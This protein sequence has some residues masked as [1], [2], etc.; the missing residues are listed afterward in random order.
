MKVQSDKYLYLPEE[1][2]KMHDTCML[3]IKQMEDFITDNTY[4]DLKAF[5][6]PINESEQTLLNLYNGDI[7][8]FLLEINR[9]DEFERLVVYNLIYG[10][11]IDNCYFL[12]EAFNC[13]SKKRLV[14]SFSLLRRPLVFNMV[15][16]LRLLFEDDFLNKFIR[17]KELYQNKEIDF[18]A[19][20]FPHNLKDLLI[21]SKGNLIM[22]NIPGDV[23]Y[24][25]V[26]NKNISDS[27]I[28]MSDKAL[29]PV[30]TRI[31]NNKT[32]PMNLNFV[33][34]TPEAIH[35]QWSYIYHKMPTILLYYI[36]L[37]DTLVFS[38]L[39]LS[40]LD[41]VLSE[42]HRQRLLFTKDCFKST[43]S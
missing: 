12:Q 32:G 8:D 41:Q 19:A 14:V 17:G 11:I 37:V 7:F 23:I 27:L 20:K 28:N 29:H 24:D 33:F 18:D 25:A 40:N 6:I 1:F 4:K 30:T 34:S 10:L 31:L 21:A 16:I 36:D 35:E 39:K 43:N 22:N 9:K 3:L 26:Y 42:R 38:R 5:S 15:I 13:S 2:H